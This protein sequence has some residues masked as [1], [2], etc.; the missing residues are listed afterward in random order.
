[1]NKKFLLL[2]FFVSFFVF[3]A[4][5]DA[6]ILYILPESTSFGI[7]Q[8]FDIDVKVNT[9]ETSINATQ[10]TIHFPTDVLELLSTEKQ[11]SA[12]NFWVEEPTVSNEDGTLKFIG[13]TA[14]GVSGTALQILKMKFRARGV[15]SADLSIS[16][17]VITASDGKG[18]N[19][20]STIEGTRINIGTTI[21]EPK[22][23]PI[24][25]TVEE[26]P[27]E[28]PEQVVRQAIRALDLPRKPELRVPLYPDASKWYSHLGDT[29]VFWDIFDD[30]TKVAV[31][32]NQNPRIEPPKA[33]EE[34]FTGK[35]V[36]I[37]EDGIWYVHVQFRNN[38]GWGTVA[39]Y[40]IAIDTVA[41]L[42][43][44]ITINNEVSENPTP[45]ITF[46]T[47]D[48]F[49]GISHANIFINGK[50]PLVATTSSTTLLPQ[51]PGKHVLMIKVFDRAGNS[52]ED[53]LEFEILPLQTPT[54]DFITKSVSQGEF[55]FASGKAIS[56]GFV[57]VVIYNDKNLEVF[58]EV[59]ASDGSGKW[60]IIVEEPLARG[61]YTFTAIAR[62]ERGAISYPTDA[63]TFKI[64]AKTVVSFGGID[65][66]WF[67]ILLIVILLT[68]S[69]V[70][71]TAWYYVSEKQKRGAYK[72]MATRDVE[73]MAAML[74]HD[75]NELEAWVKSPKG[76][77]STGMQTESEH[78]FKKIKETIAKMKKYLG[79]EISKLK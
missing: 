68:I 50:G 78:Y 67:E 54:I 8:E 55:I 59:V 24:P 28:K 76:N 17:A 13:G 64:K 3:A 58:T 32:V 7:N 33:E 70:G 31:S 47:Q 14:K 34:L 42:P 21:V 4:H 73:K 74:T 16:E 20:L 5:T 56:N 23:P 9:E 18:T 30:V 63:L 45:E 79:Q 37:L 39:H 61:Q 65:F 77:L 44:E 71:L 57:D 38:V 46:E 49:S 43:F 29:I 41:P 75:V 72:I 11:G 6:A 27:V 25:S 53:D 60:E 48:S 51:P 15:G 2:S 40:R 66:A 12:F 69:G 52:V 19:V 62:D 26:K 1:M 36:G 35:S 10:A 22:V